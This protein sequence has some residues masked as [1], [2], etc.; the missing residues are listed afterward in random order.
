M[1]P[2]F[3]PFLISRQ[4]S[5]IHFAGRNFFNGFRHCLFCFD[6]PPSTLHPPFLFLLRICT[7]L[8][9]LRLHDLRFVLPN[10]VLLVPRKVADPLTIPSPPDGNRPAAR[11]RSCC[12]RCGLFDQQSGDCRTASSPY[13]HG[14]RPSF[15]GVFC[16]IQD[17]LHSVPVSLQV[18]LFQFL[19][20]SGFCELCNGICFVDRVIRQDDAGFCELCNRICFVDRVIRQDDANSRTLIPSPGRNISYKQWHDQRNTHRFGGRDLSQNGYGV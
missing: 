14:M 4:P 12:G 17:L 6:G 2:T 8:H 16:P 19:Q 3:T 15:F 13:L 18:R 1:I 5:S 7:H 9:D 11:G 10:F 20:Q